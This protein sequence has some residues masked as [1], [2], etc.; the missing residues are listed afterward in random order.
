MSLEDIILFAHTLQVGSAAT[1]FASNS[2]E[3]LSGTFGERIDKRRQGC[4]SDVGG[5]SSSS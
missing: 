3:A 5:S 1:N 4:S 2:G